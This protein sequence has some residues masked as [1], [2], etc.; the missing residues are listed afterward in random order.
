MAG[1]YLCGI[2][3]GHCKKFSVSNVILLCGDVL[4]R[5]RYVVW[6][7][8]SQSDNCNC[9]I[10]FYVSHDSD[11]GNGEY[12]SDC[13]YN[14][15][16]SSG[17]EVYFVRRLFCVAPI[18]AGILRTLFTTKKIFVSAKNARAFRSYLHVLNQNTQ[19]CDKNQ[20]TW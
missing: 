1:A 15:E 7:V 13:G 20:D 16:C 6:R 14:Y 3:V 9:A 12:S 5:I 11:D 18:A 8:R 19:P 2:C 4:Q 17:G 10:S